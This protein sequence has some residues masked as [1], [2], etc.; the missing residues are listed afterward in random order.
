MNPLLTGCDAANAQ[1]SFAGV[2]A[3][4]GEEAFMSNLREITD[5]LDKILRLQDFPKDSSN[6][7]L[8]V[9]NAG[10]VKKICCGVDASMEFFRA[11]AERGAN[12]LIVHHG[13]SWGDSLKHITSVNYRRLKYLM[14]HDMAL[15]A[16][17]LP[18]DA[19]PRFGNNALICR[20]LGIRKTSIFGEHYRVGRKG[21]LARPMK[22]GDFEKLCRKVMARDIVSMSFGKRIVRTVAVVSGGGSSELDE[23]GRDGL[24][25]FVTGEPRL[26]AYN[27]AK[28]HRINALYAGHYA[29]EVFGVRALAGILG[30]KFKI[31]AEFVDL[32]V[33]F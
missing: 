23:A 11:A 1:L 14:D 17:H 22:L 33:K 4:F 29:T 3:M 24:D 9:E 16:C 5:F 12:L 13:M 32:K 8:Q 28:E 31:P 26:G 2:L 19:H 20:T 30:R 15:Y 18:L 25:V 6:N 21:T 10:K 27:S 7:G